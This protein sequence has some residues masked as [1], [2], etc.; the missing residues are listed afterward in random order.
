M[1]KT[2]NYKNK[3]GATGKQYTTYGDRIKVT[4]TDGS[5]RVVR[6]TDASYNATKKA[7]E[8]DIAGRNPFGIGNKKSTTTSETAIGQGV[9]EGR[10]LVSSAAVEKRAKQAT[11][12]RRNQEALAGSNGSTAKLNKTAKASEQAKIVNE[13]LMNVYRAE[14]AKAPNVLGYAGKSGLNQFTGG[15]KSV[16]YVIAQDLLTT[17]QGHKASIDNV[18]DPFHSGQSMG[19]SLR[20]I[21]AEQAQ[22][23]AALQKQY[24]YDNFGQIGKTA[25][26]VGSGI[27]NMAPALALAPFSTGGSLALM[28]LSAAGSGANK[29]LNEG[30]NLSDAATY[31]IMTGAKETG[32]EMLGGGLPLLPG[33]LKGGK[34]VGRLPGLTGTAG[35]VA[36]N[37]MDIAIEGGEEALTEYIDP[38]LQRKTYNPNAKDASLQEIGQAAL[39]GSLTAG[40]L[41]GA[42]GGV[43]I[44]RNGIRPETAPQIKQTAAQG[45]QNPQNTAGTEII[46]DVIDNTIR[47]NQGRQAA[48]N[49]AGNL[50]GQVQNGN[51]AQNHAIGP[52]LQRPQPNVTLEMAE[53]DWDNVK[54]SKVKAYQQENPAVRP[55]F[56]KQAAILL[57]DV[58]NGIKGGRNYSFNAETRNAQALGT[59][60]RLQSEPIEKMLQAGMAYP[61][62]E[63]GLQRLVDDHGRENTVNAKRAEIFVADSLQNGYQ[64]LD[65]SIP[66]SEE[67]L[68]H[69]M[70]ASDLQA[71]L[72]QLE[73]QIEQVVTVEDAQTLIEQAS[74]IYNRLQSMQKQE[75]TVSD[76]ETVQRPEQLVDWKNVQLTDLSTIN[77]DVLNFYDKATKNSKLDIAIVDGLPDTVNGCFHNGRIY[78]NAKRATDAETVRMIFSHELFHGMTKTEGYDS[79]INTA[80]DWHKSIYRAEGLEV[81]R[82]DLI[83][84]IRQDYA[85]V[86]NGQVQLS[87]DDAAAELG[88][89]FMEKAIT[90]GAFIDKLV[91]Q[92]PHIAQRIWQVLKEWLSGFGKQKGGTVTALEAEQ[93]AL[94]EKAQRLYEKSFRQLQR[95]G[96]ERSEHTNYMFAGEQSQTAD[97]K[98]LTQAQQMK[99][100]GINMETIRQETG[101]FQS[102][103]TGGKW[104]YEIDDSNAMYRE[105]GDANFRKAHPEYVEYLNLMDKMFGEGLTEAEESRLQELDDIWGSEPGRLYERLTEGNTQLNDVLEHDALYDAY[106]QLKNVRVRAEEMNGGINGSHSSSENLISVNRNGF[107]PEKTVLHEAQHAIQ[108]VEGFPKGA[109]PEYWDLMTQSAEDGSKL[110]R[111][112][113]GEIMAKDTAERRNFSAEQRRQ[114]Q[115]QMGDADTVYAEGGGKDSGVRYSIGYTTDQKPVVVIEDIRSMQIKIK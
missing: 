48:K 115:P 49:E 20:N 102:A 54:D 27:V 29:A 84:M 68:Y 75:A 26:E 37:A 107:M 52:E 90:D 42:A 64:S 79:L 46:Q 87:E 51:A 21:A 67:Y 95:T 93:R 81:S 97:R 18:A 5:T 85:A 9:T 2:K 39:L 78:M 61:Q 110:Y 22:K 57:N 11:Q 113:A 6:P 50:S 99:A 43:N 56:Q 30:A 10:G 28:G 106:P 55:M 12:A 71:Q 69:G 88:A 33:L 96:M 40:V 72:Q 91:A 98:A 59:T 108:D 53:R 105:N 114:K 76:A 15:M 89:Q 80:L 111:N 19:Q 94:I 4:Y 66:A 70:T 34:I 103:V 24:G 63:D 60:E 58:R 25:A 1:A 23:Q 17:A 7:M 83:E 101:W 38:F 13:A 41:K 8:S 73:S 3:K 65:G 36:G 14:A 44:V 62:I 82:E 74:G 92:R 32:T 31:G 104:A 77:Q 16:P 109:N 86:T 100:A 35:R 112:T 45:A 47:S